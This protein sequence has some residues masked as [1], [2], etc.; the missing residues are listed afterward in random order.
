MI[1]ANPFPIVE[2]HLPDPPPRWLVEVERLAADLQRNRPEL[3][4][5][6][7]LAGLQAT[8]IDDAPILH[9]DDQSDT[10]LLEPAREICFRQDMA[11]LRAGDGDL[12]GACIAP[13]GEAR[14]IATDGSFWFCGD[15]V[16][17]ICGELTTDYLAQLLAA[18]KME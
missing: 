1:R 14:H 10:S 18:T 17:A 4:I 9:L 12:V 16:V 3:R 7:D 13:A 11:R 6:D 15:F 5:R 8:A 2:R